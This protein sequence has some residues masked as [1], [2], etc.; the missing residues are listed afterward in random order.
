MLLQI[1]AVGNLLTRN[2]YFPATLPLLFAEAVALCIYA[3][4]KLHLS[5]QVFCVNLY[6]FLF[7]M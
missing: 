6:H 2:E 7:W 1:I 3:L 5:L 4:L